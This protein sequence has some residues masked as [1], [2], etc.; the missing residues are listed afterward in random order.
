MQD[1]ALSGEGR[2]KFQGDVEQRS[3]WH[4]VIGQW[5]FRSLSSVSMYLVVFSLEGMGT[6]RTTVRLSAKG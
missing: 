6:D 2:M 3:V 5:V 1:R 4:R